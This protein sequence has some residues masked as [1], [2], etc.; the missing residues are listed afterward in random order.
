MYGLAMIASRRFGS[1]RGK[2]EIFTSAARRRVRVKV[3]FGAAIWS[4]HFCSA[5]WSVENE[6]WR[7]RTDF[8]EHGEN[9]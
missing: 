7:G 2:K 8:R 1:E 9:V 3:R 4:L 5:Y 6:E